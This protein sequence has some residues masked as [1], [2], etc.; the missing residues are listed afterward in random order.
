MY[1]EKTPEMD[2]L[3]LLYPNVVSVQPEMNVIKKH[4]CGLVE[5]HDEMPL[6]TLRR[7]TLDQPRRSWYRYQMFQV[8]KLFQVFLNMTEEFPETLGELEKELLKHSKDGR[9]DALFRIPIFQEQIGTLLRYMTHD[10][11]E[12]PKARKH[13]GQSSEEEAAGHAIVQLLTY[14]ALRGINT[15][16]A[17][18]VALV[19]LRG[20][21]FM[22]KKADG[23]VIKGIGAAI[24]TGKIRGEAWV[25]KD[26][27]ILPRYRFSQD[28][29][30]LVAYHT[31]ADA[32]LAMFSGIITDQG[33]INCH[34]AIIAR[35]HGIPCIAGTG[36]ATQKIQTGD[37]IEMDPFN[38][39]VTIVGG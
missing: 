4:G 34:A 23:D 14:C 17:V 37:L 22:E 13:A 16:K 2:I 8:W 20:K 10:P 38:G 25:C 32:R 5:N 6:S 30:I 15:Q 36:N 12:N 35:E 1:M 29:I 9:S 21:E 33:G 31:E 7:G 19:H 11:I 27:M 39:I 24:G 18:N 3:V 26:K 28:P